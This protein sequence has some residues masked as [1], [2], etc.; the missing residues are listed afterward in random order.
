MPIFLHVGC[1]RNSKEETTEGFNTAEWKEL[2][3]DIDKAVEPDLIGTMTDMSAVESGSVDAVFSSHNIEHV[4]PHE[5]SIVLTE[6]FRILKPTG[7]VVITCPDVQSV[8]ALIAAGKLL[9]PVYDSPAGP[10]SPIDIV[11]GLRHAIAR[12]T[13]TWRIAPDLPAMHCSVR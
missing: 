9:E 4:F 3:F 7:F 8:C 2:R 12:E 13:T 1:G 10:I 6:F 11:F 5:V